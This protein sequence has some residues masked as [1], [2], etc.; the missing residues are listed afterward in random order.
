VSGR[1]VDVGS[2]WFPENNGTLA[3]QEGIAPAFSAS[4]TYAVGDYVTYEGLLY[5]CTT[6]VSTAGAWDATKWTA[7]AVMG[8]AGGDTNVIESVQVNGVALT[9]DANKAVDIAVPAKIWAAS[10]D[11]YNT[12]TKTAVITPFGGG[13]ELVN[14]ATIIVRCGT[15]ISP[16]IG[17]SSFKINVGGKGAKTVVAS[18]TGTSEIYLPSDAIQRG[19]ILIFSYRSTGSGSWFMEG[20]SKHSTNLTGTPTAPTAT[21]GT[22]TTQIATTAFVQTAV[23]GKLNATERNLLAYAS[24]TTLAPETAVYRSSLNSDGTFPTITDTGIPTTAAYYQFE[25]ELTVPSTAPSTITGPSGWVWLDGHGLP[26]PADLSG[27]ETIYIS[28]RLDC[29]ARTFLASVWRVA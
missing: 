25:L 8:E 19:D 5:K 29:T 15:S 27:G 20:V 16:G 4:S 1:D 17:G 11:S 12:T 10:W 7:V 9:P 22:N 26:D 18:S 13:F 14:D 24:T 21:A 2:A 6:A 3:L 28:V 23:G